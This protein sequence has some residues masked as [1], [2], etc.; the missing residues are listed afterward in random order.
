MSPDGGPRALAR[1]DHGCGR[2]RG[3]QVRIRGERPAQRLRP[4]DRLGH[5]PPRCVLADDPRP[6]AGGPP[7]RDPSAALGQSATRV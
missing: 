2:D 4:G 5:G 7:C 3:A 1:L 6:F